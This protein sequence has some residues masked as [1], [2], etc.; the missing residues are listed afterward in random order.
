VSSGGVLLEPPAPGSGPPRTARHEDPKVIQGSERLLAKIHPC[1]FLRHVHC[2]DNTTGDEFRFS[3]EPEQL[4]RFACRQNPV[5]RTSLP[6]PLARKVVSNLM[7]DFEPNGWE[8]QGEMID[9]WM[10]EFVTAV[11]KARQIGVTWCA[12][13]VALW[14]VAMIPGTRVLCQSITEKDAHDIVDHAWEMYLSLRRLK[15]HLVQHLKLTRPTNNRRPSDEIEFEHPGGKASRF[16]AIPSTTAAGHGRTAAFV[17]MDEFARHAYARESYKAMVPTQAG[18]KKASG[19][20]A[21][22]STGN[23]VSTDAESGNFFHY[24]WTNAKHYGVRKRFLRWDINPDRDEDWYSSVALKLP[25]RDRGEQYPRDELEAFILTGDS[26]FDVADLSWFAEERLRPSAYSFDWEV[27]EAASGKQQARQRKGEFGSIDVFLEP[28]PGRDYAIG[29]DVATG[30]GRDYSCA[31]VVDLHSQALVCELHEKIDAAAFAEQ[32][33]YLGRWYNTALI[34]V[35][36]GGGWG[37]QVLTPL[38]DGKDGRPRYT[39]L[40]RHTRP[41]SLD[42]ADQARAFGFPIS[43]A[44]RSLVISQLEKALRE[45]SLPFIPPG[46]LD[47]CRTFVYRKQ[48]PS[49]A[50]ADGCNDDRVMSAALALEMFRRFGSHQVLF[51]QERVRY[52]EPYPWR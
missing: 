15:P 21:I 19:R 16:N 3:F 41:T 10:T 32:L 11:L 26:F 49:P 46:L 9:W 51:P 37:E 50:A 24:L 4:I 23:G 6:E 18:S 1:H 7:R 35:E 43:Q 45:R 40:Y 33:H 36:K 12:A 17:I 44:T 29:V 25:V 27:V 22:I 47:E 14:Y 20:T 13:G 31:Y 30:Y 52:V 2:V 48:A 38:R 42:A 34:A 8:W 5:T 28:E 39:R